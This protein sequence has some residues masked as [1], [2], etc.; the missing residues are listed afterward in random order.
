MKVESLKRPTSA[1]K[2][3]LFEL[4]NPLRTYFIIAL[5]LV[6]ETAVGTVY[7]S[8]GSLASV[9]S[10]LTS[11]LNNQMCRPVNGLSQQAGKSMN[12]WRG[13]HGKQFTCPQAVK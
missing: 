13:D 2:N 12:H 9:S 6:N 3:A 10:S 1:S 4:E 5:S 11:N 8:V 7:A